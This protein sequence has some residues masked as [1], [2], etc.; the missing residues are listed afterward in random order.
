[1]VVLYFKMNAFVSAR[2][3]LINSH[4]VC[5]SIG[6]SSQ[7]RLLAIHGL[8]VKNLEPSIDKDETVEVIKSS[9]L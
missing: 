5:Q 7:Y 4:S 2:L 3:I 6:L 8:Q 1:M 9:S